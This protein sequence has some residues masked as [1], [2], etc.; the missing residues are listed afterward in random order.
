MKTIYFDC[1][2]GAA[3]DMIVGALLDAGADWDG[4]RK[5]LSSLPLEGYTVSTRAL[6]KRGIMTTKFDVEVEEA[7]QPHRHL[8]HC[9]E[10]IDGGDFPEAVKAAS[11]ETFRRI[12]EAEAK[13]H[14]STIEKVHFHEVGAVDSIVDIV[15]AHWCLHDLGIEQCL[16]SELVTGHGTVDCAD[17]VM[18]VPAPATAL[19]IE[20]I[21]WRQGEIDKEL[22]TPTAAAFLAQVSNGFG[23]IP[24]MTAARTGYGSG[25]MDLPHHA[26]ALRVF[27]GEAAGLGST[28]EITIIETHVDDMLPEWLPGVIDEALAQGARDAFLTPILGKK[29]RP[30]HCIT[31]LCDEGDAGRLARLLLRH[32]TTFGVRMRREPR[33]VL[34]R[35]L[36]GVDTPYGA[37]RVKVG[38]LDGVILQRSPEHADCD[39]RA[40][41]ANVPAHQVYA[42]ALAAAQAL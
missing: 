25:T 6:K 10:I 7:K 16:A 4:L 8:H 42:A 2:C 22:L 14:G 13:V 34:E 29:G 1:Y 30:A 9:V 19:L 36:I 11:R 41:E 40:K 37:V 28:E 12:A 3:G 31:V 35:E 18:P 17:G 15:A 33:L 27:I 5:A 20:G 26:N 32:T 23:P 38:K 24:R 21:P 39:A